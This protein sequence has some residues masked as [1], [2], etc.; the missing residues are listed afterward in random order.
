MVGLWT[1]LWQ[2]LD[3][4]RLS[5][6]FDKDTVHIPD[7]FYLLC[8]THTGVSSKIELNN[9]HFKRLGGQEMLDVNP[10]ELILSLREEF[11]KV[12]KSVKFAFRNEI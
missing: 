9:E 8:L 5:V 10:N 7:N 2:K 1:E 4:A 11:Q 3:D 12:Q 6:I